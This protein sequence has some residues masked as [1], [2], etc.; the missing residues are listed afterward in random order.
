MTIGQPDEAALRDRETAAWRQLAAL[1]P[2]D[3]ITLCAS[4]GSIDLIVRT[5][6]AGDDPDL[7]KAFVTCAERLTRAEVIVVQPHVRAGFYWIVRG[8]MS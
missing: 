1:R 6:H 7:S 5:V 8:W 4:A 2:F 3:K